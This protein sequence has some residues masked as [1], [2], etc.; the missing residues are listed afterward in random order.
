MNN[1]NIDAPIEHDLGSVLRTKYDKIDPSDAIRIIEDHY[2]IELKIMSTSKLT[3]HEKYLLAYAKTKAHNFIPWTDIENIEIK[4][5]NNMVFIKFPYIN[6]F[7]ICEDYKKYDGNG[8][9][10]GW[11]EGKDVIDYVNKEY[12][13]LCLLRE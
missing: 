1:F 8:S 5:E 9:W 7:L 11:K 12:S 4:K 3:H 10:V 13:E 2:D 6:D